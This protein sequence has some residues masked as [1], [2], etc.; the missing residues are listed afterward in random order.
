MYK[1]YFIDGPH[2]GAHTYTR[3][4]KPVLQI[5]TGINETFKYKYSGRWVYDDD[6]GEIIRFYVFQN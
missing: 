3:D 1:C 6:D 5:P 4:V 2:R